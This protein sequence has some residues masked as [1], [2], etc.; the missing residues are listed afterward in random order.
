MTSPYRTSFNT[1]FLLAVMGLI[2]LQ[3]AWAVGRLDMSK[4]TVIAERSSKAGVR[5]VLAVDPDDNVHEIGIGLPDSKEEPAVEANLGVRV[6][7]SG[8]LSLISVLPK[9]KIPTIV[10]RVTLGDGTIIHVLLA[11]GFSEFPDMLLPYSHLYVF[12]ERR[13]EASQLTSQEL[14]SE[15][16]QFVVEDINRDGNVEILVATRD[17]SVS[18][19]NIWQIQPDGQVKKIQRID[20]YRVHTLADRFI[21]PQQGIIVENKVR[22][23]APGMACFAIDEYLWSDKQRRFVKR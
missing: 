3:P 11:W 7:N 5:V 8:S 9:D 13:G 21:G 16:E 14:G 6:A 12:R 4:Q 1:T 2:L 10:R 19:M 17:N 22:Y 23:P 18:S 20:G 15:L